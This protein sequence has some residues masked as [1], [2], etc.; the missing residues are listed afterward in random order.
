MS[1][2]LRRELSSALTRFGFEVADVPDYFEALRKLDEFKP[3]LVILDEELSLLDGW[4]ACYQLHR[5]FGIPVILLGDDSSSEV[6]VKVVE[7]GAD[8][9]LRM[10]FSYF[11][12]EHP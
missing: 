5:T 10:P 3:D 8:F 4:K 11:E 7:A 1:L 2:L 6:W 12:L 9:Y